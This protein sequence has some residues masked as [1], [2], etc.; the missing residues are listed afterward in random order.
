MFKPLKPMLLSLALLFLAL[1]CGQEN[2]IAPT[3]N[4]LDLSTLISDHL[5]SVAEG[6]RAS[7]QTFANDKLVYALGK[8]HVE[9]L[10]G[11]N[12]D[13][14]NGFSDIFDNVVYQ[15]GRATNA[16]DYLSDDAK[17]YLIQIQES[18]GTSVHL[19]AF[20]EKLDEIDQSIISAPISEVEKTVLRAEVISLDISLTFMAYNFELFHPEAGAYGRTSEGGAECDASENT[21]DEKGPTTVQDPNWWSSWGKCA[22]SVI[23]GTG[24]GALAGG[25]FGL[26]IGTLLA[27]P[28]K[29]AII[30]GIIGGV[31]GGIGAAS[32]GC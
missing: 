8:Q 2:E 31:A 19:Q 29:G 24:A 16:Q 30:G 20:K 26:K 10:Y 23:G 1:S 14:S 12:S 17:Q 13:A 32:V 11:V 21:C 3:N 7:K 4:K 18:A 9:G 15:N 6:L 28:L 25:E 5:N 22:A 27:S